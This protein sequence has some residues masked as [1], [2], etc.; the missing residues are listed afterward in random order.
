MEF[1]FNTTGVAYLRTIC[2]TYRSAGVE[3]VGQKYAACRI[4]KSLRTIAY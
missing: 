1:D 2:D 3:S 4:S